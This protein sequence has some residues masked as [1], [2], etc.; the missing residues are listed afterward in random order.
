MNSIVVFKEFSLL[1]FDGKDDLKI[2]G[3]SPIK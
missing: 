2:L 1:S 3:G